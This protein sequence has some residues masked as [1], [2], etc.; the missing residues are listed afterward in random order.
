LQIKP[1]KKIGFESFFY[2]GNKKIYRKFLGIGFIIV[3]AILIRIKYFIGFAL[4]D[5]LHYFKMVVQSK[6]S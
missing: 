4:G 6:C 1:S 5:D 3:L 2:M